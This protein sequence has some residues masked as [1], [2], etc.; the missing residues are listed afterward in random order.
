MDFFTVVALI[1]AIVLFLHL[2]FA[3]LYPEKL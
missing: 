2:V 1:L 3:L